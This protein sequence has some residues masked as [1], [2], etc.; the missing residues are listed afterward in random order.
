MRQKGF[1][2]VE[3]LVVLAVGS[4]ILTGA[5]LSIQQVLVGTDRSKSQV[6]ALA[7][8]NQ[9][10]LKIKRDLIMTQTANLTDGSLIPRSSVRLSWI[11]YT[12]FS[13]DNWTS[14][15]STYNLSGTNLQRTYDGVTSIVGR[16]ITSV[17]F[18]RNGRVISVVITATG[19]GSQ[20]RS[21]TLEFSAYL[22]SE[23]IQ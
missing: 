5:L 12:G 14:H 8:I 23:P 2:L 6:V 22:R 19:S 17:G 21:K 4:V 11:D 1:T 10:V 16:H 9:A 20:P 3:I 15:S 18:T 13:S 7:D